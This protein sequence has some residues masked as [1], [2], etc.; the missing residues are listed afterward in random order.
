MGQPNLSE[1]VEMLINN[2]IC[3]RFYVHIKRG[4]GESGELDP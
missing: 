3:H 2:Y 1:N 4:G